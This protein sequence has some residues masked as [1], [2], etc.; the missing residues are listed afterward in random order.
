MTLCISACFNS[1]L[2]LFV[3]LL[4]IIKALSILYVQEVDKNSESIGWKS[5]VLSSGYLLLRGADSG[6][7]G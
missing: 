5:G 1:A 6:F 4:T 2:K 7:G 3:F